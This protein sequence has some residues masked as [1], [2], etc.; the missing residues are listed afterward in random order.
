[1]SHV[2]PQ[3]LA[4]DGAL[5][6][7]PERHADD[8]GWTGEVVSPRI[9][10]NIGVAFVPVQENQSF[11]HQAG[12]VRGL[13]F[14]RPPYTQ[15][16]IVRVAHGVVLSVVV[17]LRAGRSSFEQCVVVRQTSTSGESLFIPAGCAHGIIA[18][19]DATTLCWTNDAPF[20][21]DAA[22][23]L[24]AVD[25]ALAIDWPFPLSDTL[26]SPRDAALPT[27]ALQPFRFDYT[28]RLPAA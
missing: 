24:N 17:D 6:F 15:A 2:K 5:L 21:A 20:N 3:P 1:M 26:V 10:E 12:I 11:S 23:G 7:S 27:L 25:P 28:G 18:L 8:R 14:Q 13:H 4:I 9:L 16:K 19:Q 22:D